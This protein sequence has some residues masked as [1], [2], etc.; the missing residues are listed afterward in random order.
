VRRSTTL[1]RDVRQFPV[2]IP[3]IVGFADTMPRF[4]KRQDAR[5]QVTRKLNDELRNQR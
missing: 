4:W 1:S 3:T 5:Q 2:L